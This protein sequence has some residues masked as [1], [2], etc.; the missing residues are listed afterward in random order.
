M[1]N[2]GSCGGAMLWG[3]DS[4]LS[5]K[6]TKDQ[7]DHDKHQQPKPKPQRGAAAEGETEANLGPRAQRNQQQLAAEALHNP[8]KSKTAKQT[9][10]NNKKTPSGAPLTKQT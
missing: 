5:V 10:T 1:S 4:R 9:T 3:W 6:K 7:D 2:N 8:K